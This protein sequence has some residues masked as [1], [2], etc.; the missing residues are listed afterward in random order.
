[1]NWLRRRVVNDLGQ[2]SLLKVRSSNLRRYMDWM[3]RP[4]TR[5]ILEFPINLCYLLL[6]HRVWLPIHEVLDGYDLLYKV[7]LK[8]NTRNI[9]CLELFPQ[10]IVVHS[11]GPPLIGF[12]VEDGAENL[13]DVT[14]DIWIDA[15]TPLRVNQQVG[16]LRCHRYFNLCIG[17]LFLLKF[18]LVNW[19][20]DVL[21]D[22][23]QL[24][25]QVHQS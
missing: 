18:S 15:A 21:I 16:W 6:S 14:L 10:Y 1:M 9:N 13:E 5:Q 4:I 8:A 19:A 3:R 24:L 23:A 17:C 2:W 7:V 12:D 11:V 20:E 25:Q 22:E